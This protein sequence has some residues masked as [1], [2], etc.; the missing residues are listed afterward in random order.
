MTTEA[1]KT[2]VGSYFISNYPPFSQ[3]SAGQ[4]DDVQAALSI[5]AAPTCRWGCTCT[6][7]SAASG[8]SSAT[9]TSS[10]TRTRDQ[11]ERYVAALVAR[12]RAGQ[13]RAGDGRP[14]VS[15]RL[16][17]RRHAVVPQREAAHVAGRSA[18]RRTSTGTRPRKS[19]SS[20][21][22][23][24]SSEPKVHA[25]RELGVTRL[26]LGV[27]NFD[28]AI[29]DENGRAHVSRGDLQVRGMDS[30]PPGFPTSTST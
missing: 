11:V 16:F 21:S 4:L 17:R 5:A 8:A 26:S 13:P 10:P 27:E 1:T 22:R 30:A 20:A 2:E 6:F 3:W 23:A 9:S 29:L 18:A 24:R 28:D 19:R 14:A 12:D 25:L 7:R 15:L